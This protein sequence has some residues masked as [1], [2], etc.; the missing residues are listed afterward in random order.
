MYKNSKWADEL[1]ARQKSDGSWGYFHSLSE[2]S[3]Q[4]VTTEQALRRLSILGFTI[5]ENLSKGRSAI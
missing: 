2:P 3:K 1:I 4:P 5:E